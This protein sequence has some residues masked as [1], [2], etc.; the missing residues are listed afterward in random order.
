MSKKT[1]AK[2]IYDKLIEAKWPGLILDEEKQ[3]I[4]AI[5]NKILIILKNE[6]HLNFYWYSL[7]ENK[8]SLRETYSEIIFPKNLNIRNM[9]YF[10][11][12]GSYKL[13]NERQFKKIINP[14]NRTVTKIKINSRYKK[15]K[16]YKDTLLLPT[17][18]FTKA[19]KD[20]TYVY[21][22]SSTYKNSVEN[23]LSN[24]KSHNYS[25]N[26]KKRT[27][28]VEKGEFDF[29]VNRLYLKTKRSKKDFLNYFNEEDTK[30]IEKLITELLKFD[31][32]SDEFLRRLDNYF[33]KERLESIIKLGK[34]I[35]S[36][37]STNL[38]TTAARYII[39]KI[40]MDQVDQ[41]ESI[42]QK[43]FEKN[44][45]Y[46]IFTYKKIYP[47]VEL[48]N[49]EG[50]KKYPDFIG[51]N[52]FNGLDIIEIKTH[53]KNILV[54]DSSHQNFYFSS[55]MSKAIVQTTNYMDAI[56][57]QRFNIAED[58]EKITQFTD[59]ENLYHPRGIIVISSEGKLSSKTNENEK[60]K[61]D[62]TK[63]R[64][65]LQNIEILTFDEIINIAT[66][67]IKNIIPK[68]DERQN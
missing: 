6:Y 54:W 36:L 35:L 32:L 53:L 17:S 59:E 67:Y 2:F 12:N 38:N 18:L 51:I 65:S 43:Y 25:N 37:R 4:T 13:F 40:G 28:Y 58:K 47:K 45:L 9:L 21:T 49:I 66:E 34:Q 23:Y 42:W 48:K 20:A 39:N 11:R 33:I 64:S 68:I 14:F 31:V 26:V 10:K 30:S 5:D 50:D 19:I 46:L 7:D 27:T 62:F 16:F 56:V 60:L 57:Q 41:L 3:K 55:E 29:L 52:H 63:L 8:Y 1:L 22:I 24:V 15:L 61:R 44:L